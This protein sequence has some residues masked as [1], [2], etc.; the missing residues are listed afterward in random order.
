QADGLAR[1]LEVPAARGQGGGVAGDRLRRVRR[2]VRALRAH[3]ERAPDAAG[4]P[5]HQEGPRRHPR[6]GDA[7]GTGRLTQVPDR[8][9]RVG[10]IGFGTIGAGVVKLLRA[11][12]AEIARRAGRPVVL[13]T[14]GDL[15]PD[16]DRG[17][18]T[19]GIRLTRDAA[20]LIAYPAIDVVVELI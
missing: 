11:H 17:V 4:D 9:V 20:G 19:T 14:I 5:R 3:R 18:A 6:A 13:T 2:S 8:S 15:D 16:P 7:P 1:V 12:R 10:L